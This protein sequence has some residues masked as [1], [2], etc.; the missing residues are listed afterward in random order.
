MST[1]FDINNREYFALD[2]TEGYI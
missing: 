1:T 2:K